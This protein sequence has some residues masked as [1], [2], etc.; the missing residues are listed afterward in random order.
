ME[1]RMDALL[2]HEMD[3]D[4]RTHLGH[5]VPSMEKEV[6]KNTVWPVNRQRETM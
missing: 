6:P 5:K 3:Q 2:A 1:I 4:S